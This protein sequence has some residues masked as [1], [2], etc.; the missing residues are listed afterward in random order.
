MVSQGTPLDIPSVRKHFPALT[1]HHFVFADNAGGTQVLAGVVERMGEYLTR[2]NVQMA[3]YGFAARAEE[4]VENGKAAA[5]AF[6]GIDKANLMVGASATQLFETL[7][8]MM[9]AKVLERRL[10]QHGEAW[11]QGD[12]IVITEADHEADRGAWIRLA[13]RLDL[14]VKTWKVSALPNARDKTHVGLDIG[15]LE[16]I[17]TAKT[18]L[19][20]FTASSNVLGSHWTDDQFRSIVDLVRRKTNDHA[21]VVVDAVAFAPHL[22]LRPKQWGVDAVVWSWY[23]VFGPHVGSMFVSDRAK[24]T[25]LAKLNHHFLH[26]YTGSMYPYEPSSE[27]YE[28]IASLASIIDYLV[29]LGQDGNAARIDYA[30]ADEQQKER[31]DSALDTAFVRISQHESQLATA[32]LQGLNRLTDSGI[33]IVGDGNPSSL[34]HRAPTVAF[35]VKDA[36]IA[37]KALHARM[38]QG[39]SLGAQVGHMYAYD[40]I[41]ALP[42]V[43]VNDGVVRVS[44]V[45]YN[46]IAEVQTTLQTIERTLTA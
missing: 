35:L 25:I 30:H 20:A 42:D 13:K 1:Q 38:V 26:G 8:R 16:S 31:I 40:L 22:R 3:E 23:K 15:T 28:L 5:A 21:F 9:E 11:R 43:D 46:T 27:Q 44:F 24:N 2:T 18:R 32:L 29:S 19:V 4:Q 17:V 37:S 10:S 33:A 36:R 7:S 12:E 41:K 6:A 34:A 39:H 45:H 14:T